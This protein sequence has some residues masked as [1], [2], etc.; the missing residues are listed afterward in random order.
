MPGPALPLSSSTVSNPTGILHPLSYRMYLSCLKERIKIVQNVMGKKVQPF[1]EYFV[2]LAYG[3]VN[4][5]GPSAVGDGYIF[6][7]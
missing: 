2:G 5:W 4:S 1:L 7:L 6:S 3:F